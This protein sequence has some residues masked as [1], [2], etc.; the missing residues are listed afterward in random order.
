MIQ[1][2]KLSNQSAERGPFEKALHFISESQNSQISHPVMIYM[3]E[4]THVH[5]I[6]KKCFQKKNS[7]MCPSREDKGIS[8]SLETAD[9]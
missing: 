6:L 7:K 8:A 9:K 1:L 2:Q 3:E 4:L 5:P